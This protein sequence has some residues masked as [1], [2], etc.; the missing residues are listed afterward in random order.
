MKVDFIGYHGCEAS[1]GERVRKTKVFRLSVGDQEWLG[2]GV[3]F[4]EGDP[5]PAR[6]WVKSRRKYPKW[7][8]LKADISAAESQVL[9]L[10]KEDDFD[11]FQRSLRM[12]VDHTE[13][14]GAPVVGFKDGAVINALCRIVPCKVVRAPFD[15]GTEGVRRGY[16]RIRKTHIQLAVRDP[17]CIVGIRLHERSA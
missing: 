7:E 12:L 1:V 6:W 3:Y 17:S 14:L 11:E 2:D 9:D 4:F 10:L 15:W 16:S 5:G 13:T 8:I